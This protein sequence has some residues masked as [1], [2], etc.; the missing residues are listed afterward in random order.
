MFL[1]EL[2]ERFVDVYEVAFGSV[3]KISLG[4]LLSSG[5]QKYEV[6]MCVEHREYGFGRVEKVREVCGECSIIVHFFQTDQKKIFLPEHTKDLT[7]RYDIKLEGG[8]G[9]YTDGG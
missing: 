9:E 3:K 2:D 7:I 4:G 1:F 6:N 5:F 8:D